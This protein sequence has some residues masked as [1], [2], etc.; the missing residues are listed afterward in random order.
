MN[1]TENNLYF[2]LI[3]KSFFLFQVLDPNNKL[4]YSKEVPIN[5][6][7]VS[8]IYIS[9]ENFLKKYFY[10]RKKFKIFY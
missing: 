8:D 5:Y 6:N 4:I 9:I 7:L 3:K 10:N 2:I 1:K